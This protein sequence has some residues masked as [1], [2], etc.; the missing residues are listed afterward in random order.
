[1]AVPGSSDESALRGLKEV[2]KMSEG[3]VPDAWSVER[4]RGHRISL[5]VPVRLLKGAGG[6]PKVCPAAGESS[7]LSPSGVCLTT[8]DPGAFVPG[9]VLMVSIEIPWETRRVFPFSRILG[10]CRVVRVDEQRLALEF[11]GEDTTLLGAI[12]T[13]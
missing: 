8:N 7:D 5:A 4:R 2:S 11:C 3:G 10:P 12:V 13:S 6:G 9:E 1:M